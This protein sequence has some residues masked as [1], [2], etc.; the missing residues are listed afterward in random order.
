MVTTRAFA[1]RCMKLALDIERNAAE[2]GEDAPGDM[3]Q[4]LRAMAATIVVRAKRLGCLDAK[5]QE[6]LQLCPAD[7]QARI[8][9]TYAD[10]RELCSEQGY[11]IEQLQLCYAL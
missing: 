8:L 10:A 6:F 2:L 4:A 5:L 11:E 7:M 3:T 9:S 1:Q